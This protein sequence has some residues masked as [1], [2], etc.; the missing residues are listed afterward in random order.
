MFIFRLNQVI[1]KDNATRKPVLGLAGDDVAHVNFLSI[2]TVD[3]QHLP[4]LDEFKD[5][6]TADE[7]AKALKPAIERTLKCQRLD[8][9]PGVRDGVPISFGNYGVALYE[10]Q[11][12]PDTLNWRFAAFKSKEGVR[13]LGSAVNAVVAAPEFNDFTNNLSIVL[14]G[15]AATANPAYAAG[16]AIAEFAAEVF[17]K[18]MMAQGDQKL[19]SI[20][21]SLNRF[22]HYYFAQHQGATIDTSQNMRVDY[23]IFGYAR[24]I[25]VDPPAD[26]R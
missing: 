24:A 25:A 16:M 5:A 11:E 1:L 23:S 18:S 14:K 12:I 6:T 15:A 22:E 19:G 9:V 3:N 17:A 8:G 2:V 7:R 26:P 10:D 21:M 20:S 4:N 13:A